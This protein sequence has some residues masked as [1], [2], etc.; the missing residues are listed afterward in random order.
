MISADY[1]YRDSNP[2]LPFR[3]RCSIQ[4]SYKT[5]AKVQLFFDITKSFGQKTIKILKI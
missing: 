5:A 1:P 2:D 3:R 4:L